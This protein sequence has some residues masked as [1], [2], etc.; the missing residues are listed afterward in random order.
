[1]RGIHDIV[2]Y[3]PKPD[4]PRLINRLAN[5]KRLRRP[6]CAEE[7][8]VFLIIFF[9]RTRFA[10]RLLN[11]G[12]LTY[13]A[14]NAI[15]GAAIYCTGGLATPWTIKISNLD[16]VRSCEG[17]YRL[18]TLYSSTVHYLF[19]SVRILYGSFRNK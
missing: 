16:G 17:K 1:D 7:I 19:N 18:V 15:G 9:Y 2:L 11:M 14:V 4:K 13:L 10:D 12:L 3:T 5:Q 8:E 6:L